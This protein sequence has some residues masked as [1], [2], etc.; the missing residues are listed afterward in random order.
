MSTD[1]KTADGRTADGRTADGRTADG[2]TADG[3]TADGRTADGRTEEGKDSDVV[4]LCSPT[5]D[6]E[7]V[8]AIRARLDRVEL[9]EI[10][11][12][13]EGLPV[14]AGEVA[15]LRPREDMPLVCDVDVTYEVPRSPASSAHAGP[16]RISSES[17]RRNWDRAFNSAR[18]R[19][20][21]KHELN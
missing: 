6:G 18:P 1:D 17:Y 5:A 11:P 10:R 19:R 15:R 16:P 7:G 13:K 4:V 8:R 9:A 2:R 14:V 20:P 21:P 12:L 3:R